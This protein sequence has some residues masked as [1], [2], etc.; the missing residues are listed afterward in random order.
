MIIIIHKITKDNP[1]ASS[2][3]V[4]I[5]IPTITR[6]WWVSEGAGKVRYWSYRERFLNE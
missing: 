2:R 4:Y 5:S 6:P 3:L 1:Y